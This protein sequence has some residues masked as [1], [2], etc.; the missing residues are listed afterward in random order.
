M[1]NDSMTKTSP[2]N[3][4]EDFRLGQTI[5]HATP[6][7][8]TAGDVALYNALFGARFPLQSSDMFAHAIGY[9]RAPVDD[10]LGLPHRVRQDRAGYLAQCGRQSRLCRL[11]LPARGLSGRHAHR[12]V[13]GDRPEGEFQPQ[14]RR[15][16]CALDRLQAGRRE[17]ARIRA[18]GDGA[19]ARR[20]GAGAA[21]I[22]CREL[23]EAL[24]ASD[25]R[26]RLPAD[27]RRAPTISRSPAARTASA[28]IRSARRSTTSTA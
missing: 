12:G 1:I 15:R 19:K 20:G 8:V 24:D 28:T 27:R 17:G 23:P 16:L 25:A 22:T 26:R 6:R 9:P 13:G 14:D 21:A 2:G 10:L 3:F 7:T 18:L 4:F 11:P 5:T